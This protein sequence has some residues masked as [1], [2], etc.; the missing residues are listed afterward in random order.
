MNKLNHILWG[1]VLIV[2]GAIFALN[3]LNLTDIELF[4]DG[5]WTLFILVPC[6]VGLF[7]ER[8]KTGNLIGLAAGVFLLLCCQDVL[9]FSMFWELFIPAIII[10][11]G[12]KLI[13]TALFSGKAAEIRAKQKKE[14]KK[15]K[16]AFAAFSGNDIHFGGEPFDGAELAA[17]FGGVECDLRGAVITEDCVITVTVL[18]GGIDILVPEGINVKSNVFPLFG[19][20]ENKT[21]VHKDA[22]TVY[23]NGICMFGGVEIR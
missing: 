1:I 3:A 9:S 8:E 4:F 22:P 21:T 23:I 5:W 14:G 13:F 17:I 19:G 6:A 18:F 2:A 16:T 15:P 11:I 20:A 10:I 12:L 7:T